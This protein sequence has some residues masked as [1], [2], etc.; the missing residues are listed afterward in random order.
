MLRLQIA[1]SVRRCPPNGVARRALGEPPTRDNWRSPADIIRWYCG[2]IS[3]AVGIRCRPSATG[4]EWDSLTRRA[5]AISGIVAFVVL[6]GIL[7]A[8]ALGAAGTGTPAEDLSPVTVTRTVMTV[9]AAA[10]GRVTVPVEG[11]R[12][13]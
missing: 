8:L 6:D 9:P 3:W 10:A 13:V 12:S 2:A 5:A 1:R 7:V 4:Q 11:D